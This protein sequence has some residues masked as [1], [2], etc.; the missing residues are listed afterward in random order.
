MDGYFDDRD[1]LVIDGGLRVSTA[2]GSRAPLRMRARVAA[3]V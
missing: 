1:P 2:H 3:D